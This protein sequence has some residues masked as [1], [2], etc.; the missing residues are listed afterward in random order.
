LGS[1]HFVSAA[2][3]VA[4]ARGPDRYSA[5]ETIL[6]IQMDDDSVPPDA[7]APKRWRRGATGGRRE[8]GGPT[9]KQ[10]RCRTVLDILFALI[11]VL[12]AAALGTSIPTTSAPYDINIDCTL[13]PVNH[14]NIANSDSEIAEGRN[15]S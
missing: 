11:S 4:C 8:I 10:G 1:A 14:T 15:E 3:P 2:D 5:D 12:P 13:S 6:F 7:D 9:K